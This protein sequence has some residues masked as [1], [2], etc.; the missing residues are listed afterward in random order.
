M[1]VVDKNIVT[2]YTKDYSRYI[3]RY[4]YNVE[5]E[6]QSERGK[7]HEPRHNNQSNHQS[8]F[9]RPREISGNHRS[10]HCIN[11]R[12]YRI[13]EHTPAIWRQWGLNP[14][15]Q[16]STVLSRNL[17]RQENRRNRWRNWNGII[18]PI[19]RLDT[20]GTIYPSNRWTYG[21]YSRSS[22]RKEKWN[23]L[24]CNRHRTGM[25]D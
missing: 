21:I 6:P 4:I 5:K 8:K 13:C 2:T 24:E 3:N 25:R 9:Q 23:R 7:P 19:V 11:I 20:M 15:R 1:I 10:L 22:N 12:L 18:R 16:R 14:F 17:I